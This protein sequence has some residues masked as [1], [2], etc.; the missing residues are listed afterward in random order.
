MKFENLN[1]KESQIK[2]DQL[3]SIHGGTT[4]S[5]LIERSYSENEYPDDGN[6]RPDY[7]CKP[8]LVEVEF[9]CPEN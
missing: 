6:G 8:I 2:I 1:F 7:S 4:T 5:V 3:K 9:P